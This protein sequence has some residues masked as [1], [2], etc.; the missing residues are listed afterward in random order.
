MLEYV[1][2]VLVGFGFVLFVVGI[3]GAIRRYVEH[4]EYLNEIL[5]ISLVV[6]VAPILSGLW[7]IF[8]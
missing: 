1:N 2:A 5:P 4:P 3:D 8:N 7:E 6:I